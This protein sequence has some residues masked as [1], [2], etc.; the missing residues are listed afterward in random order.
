MTTEIFAGAADAV[1]A[2]T[3]DAPVPVDVPTAVPVAV[4]VAADDVVVVDVAVVAV[5]P[6]LP[7]H[8]EISSTV[9]I[10]NADRSLGGEFLKL[11]FFKYVMLS[12]SKV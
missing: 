10:P 4:V 3:A 7:P 5:V 6:L 9:I 8:P 1:A 2:A 12:L 11:L